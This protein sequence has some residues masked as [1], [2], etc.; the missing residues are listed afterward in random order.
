MHKLIAIKDGKVLFQWNNIKLTDNIT[1]TRWGDD[2]FEYDEEIYHQILDDL[3]I[4]APNNNVFELVD[5]V[6]DCEL[7]TEIY[8]CTLSEWLLEITKTENIEF[9]FKTI[10]TF[11]SRISSAELFNLVI[12][13]QSIKIRNL[14]PNQRRITKLVILEAM[15]NV[16]C[17]EYHLPILQ[18]RRKSL[19]FELFILE[20]LEE[21]NNGHNI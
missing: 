10:P 5:I 12:F 7:I 9:Y 16:Y 2:I 11:Q 6:R 15:M 20:K 13:Q 1:A 14:T 21:V 19:D 4:S 3:N 18:K 8:E 17:R